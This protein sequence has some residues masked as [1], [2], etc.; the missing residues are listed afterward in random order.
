MCGP[1][2][3]F[4]NR[5]KGALIGA[6]LGGAAL[7]YRADKQE[8]ELRQQMQGTGVRLRGATSSCVWIGRRTRRHVRSGQALYCKLIPPLY[9]PSP[10]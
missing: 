7:G 10:L 6:A 2:F 4:D 3:L 1:F 5:G 8:A 9:Q